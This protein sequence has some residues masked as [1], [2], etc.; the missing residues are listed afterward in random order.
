MEVLKRLVHNYK[1]RKDASKEMP[2]A[3]SVSLEVPRIDYLKQLR[4]KRTTAQTTRKI[5]S[6][7]AEQSTPIKD[8]DSYQ[9]IKLKASLF[10]RHA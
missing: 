3:V 4:E 1:K 9:R 5:E 2:R 6:D 7:Y 10:D 8:V